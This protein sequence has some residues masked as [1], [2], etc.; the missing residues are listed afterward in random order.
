MEQSIT[1]LLHGHTRKPKDEPASPDQALSKARKEFM[2]I[3]VGAALLTLVGAFIV[4][5]R[6]LGTF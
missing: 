5:K 1:L 4:V 6:R 3:A 2:A